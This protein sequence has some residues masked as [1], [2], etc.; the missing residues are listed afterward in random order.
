M[1]RKPKKDPTEP[2][3]HEGM[4][5]GT[6]RLAL[7]VP[8]GIHADF[9][10]DIQDRGPQSLRFMGTG[11]VGLMMG[12][13]KD[14][15]DKI[16]RYVQRERWENYREVNSEEVWRLFEELYEIRLREKAHEKHGKK[17]SG[18]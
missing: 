7:Q 5:I 8:D 1:A 13:P 16:F 6:S 15:R 4:Q 12:M 10:L 14:I 11:A 2:R 3:R 18:T 17:G 9:R